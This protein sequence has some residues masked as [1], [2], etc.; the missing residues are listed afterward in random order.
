MKVR[1]VSDSAR[2]GVVSPA[3]VSMPWQPRNSVSKWSDRTVRSATGPTSAS[4]GVRI[5]PVRMTD[6]CDP[7]P[8]RALLNRFITR[9][10]LVTIVRPGTSSRHWASANVVV[11]ADRAIAVPGLTRLAA[12]LPI[13][14][15]SGCSST[16]LASKPGS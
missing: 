2:F 4:E 11:P 1:L 3:S 10:E 15:F 16:S 12:A 8:G 6:V 14:A 9:S 13:A 7:L 5:P